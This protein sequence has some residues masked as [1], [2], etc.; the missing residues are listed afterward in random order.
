MPEKWERQENENRKQ[1]QLFAVYRDL[2]ITRSISKVVK[3]LGKP[4]RYRGHL[5]N[6]SAQFKWVE[7]SAAYDDWMEEERRLAS[8]DAIRKMNEEGAT[9]ARQL[10]KLPI[11]RIKAIQ[12][13]LKAALE[14]QD[15]EERETLL[16]E[17][18]K[19]VPL[20]LMG[21]WLELSFNL[22]REA[23]GVGKKIEIEGSLDINK[24]ELAKDDLMR[25]VND[26]R[27]REEADRPDDQ[28]SDKPSQG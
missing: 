9:I 7:R 21:Q 11:V 25:F 17:A 24:E 14:A 23:L 4:E 18:V 3:H 13:K 12:D 1:Y 26:R 15:P 27:S 16:D 5:Q 10:R 8:I 2:G 22:E 28:G 19:E 6:L 20:H